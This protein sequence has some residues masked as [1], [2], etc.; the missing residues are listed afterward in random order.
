MDP[1]VVL[2]PEIALD[3]VVVFRTKRSNKD[4]E[5]VWEPGGSFRT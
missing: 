1:E 4:P 3:P 5:V 2:N